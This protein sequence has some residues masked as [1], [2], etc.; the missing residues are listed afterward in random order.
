[1]PET[2]EDVFV[3]GDVVVIFFGIF[4]GVLS[5][6]YSSEKTGNREEKEAED[7][8]EKEKEEEEA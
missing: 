8:K 6:L 7:E 3:V 4:G 5:F 1:M 2:P